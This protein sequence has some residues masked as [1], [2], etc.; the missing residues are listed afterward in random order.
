MC[1]GVDLIM[2]ILFEPFNLWFRVYIKFLK[3]KA[4]FPS[5]IFPSIILNEDSLLWLLRNQMTLQALW[6][7]QIL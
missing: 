6:I 2:C 7:L 5:D 3:F 4:I 1:L